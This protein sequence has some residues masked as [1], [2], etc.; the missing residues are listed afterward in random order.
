MID[1]YKV[2]GVDRNATE[3]EIK[4]AYRK[5]AKEYHPDL[6]PNDPTAAKKMN[7][8]NEAYDMLK[9]PEKYERKR[10]QEQQQSSYRQ[11]QSY[12]GN[13]YGQGRYQGQNTYGYGSQTDYED[14]GYGSY[15]GYGGGYTGFGGF[16]F[17]DLFG[18]FGSARQ[19]D[20]RPHAQP[21]DPVEM[22][23]AINAI[24]A[25]RYQEA[26]RILTGMTSS[27]RNARWYY[28]CALAYK[29]IGDDQQALSMIQR[30]AQA[31]PQNRV[32]QTL[33]S[34]YSRSDTGT[35]GSY[36]GFSSM[37]LFGVVILMIFLLSMLFRCMPIFWF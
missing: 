15:R 34:Q 10:A 23:R 30:A 4:K 37:R 8:V 5:K 16:N 29:G 13:A 14:S 7:E 18:G 17:E 24:N 35:A 25:G 2:L 12:Y 11:Q 9:N 6:H 33:Y 3:D 28:L 19:Y 22:V 31:Q 26:I 36:R 32:Y 20:T 21:N 1:P 27:Y